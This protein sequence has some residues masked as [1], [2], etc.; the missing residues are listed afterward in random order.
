MCTWFYFNF[1][2]IKKIIF[3]RFFTHII[4]YFKNVKTS[5]MK[6]H[7]EYLGN[8]IERTRKWTNQCKRILIPKVMGLK[9]TSI[10]P[11]RIT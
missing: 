1:T 5:Y 7:K 11:P 9:G 2:K 4:Y 8:H 10:T 6:N 3:D